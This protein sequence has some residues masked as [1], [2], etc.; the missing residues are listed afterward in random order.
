ML[1][2]RYFVAGFLAIVLA[3]TVTPQ[4]YK[5]KDVNHGKGFSTRLYRGQ[6]GVF[7]GQILDHSTG[8]DAAARFDF[9]NGWRTLSPYSSFQYALDVFRGDVVGYNGLAS[10]G[11][12]PTNNGASHWRGHPPTYTNLHPPGYLSSGASGIHGRQVVGYVTPG[13]GYQNRAT[14]WPSSTTY[15]VDLHPPGWTD[16]ILTA[17]TGTYQVGDAIG[18]PGQRAGFWSGTAASFVDIHPSWGVHSG[19][20]DIEGSYIAGWV[21]MPS[22]DRNATI[23]HGPNPSTALNLNPLGATQSTAF[24][25]NKGVVVGEYYL[26]GGWFPPSRACVFI[27]PYGFVDLHTLLGSN[28]VAS[29]ARGVDEHGNVIGYAQTTWGE[30]HAIIWS[31]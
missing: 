8:K 14:M 21:Q 6:G 27:G 29:T 10:V 23:W 12:V 24:G 26:P 17:T 4:G 9:Y 3:S 30:F 16:S 22:G 11:G 18:P 28:Y 2:R 19:A 5:A 13:P 20:L 7:A 1:H 15:M 25:V 31:P